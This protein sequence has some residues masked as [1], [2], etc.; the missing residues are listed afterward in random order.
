MPPCPAL[1]RFPC[2]FCLLTISLTETTNDPPVPLLGQLQDAM[3]ELS[4]G[5]PSAFSY[6]HAAQVAG[7]ELFVPMLRETRL[8][9]TPQ[10]NLTCGFF[11]REVLT[12]QMTAASSNAPRL[13]SSAWWLG[14]GSEDT[15][16][17][18]AHTRGIIYVYI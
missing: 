5:L 9:A 11:H 2:L 12:Q 17:S 6:S 3:A 15:T 16:L 4:M 13:N 1:Q 18:T 7:L 10:R 8:E 14:P